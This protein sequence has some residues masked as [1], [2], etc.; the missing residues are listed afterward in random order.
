MNRE[1][2]PEYIFNFFPLLHKKL[3]RSRPTTVVTRQQM[4]LMH[5]I[6][7]RPDKPM[8]YYGEKMLISKPNLSK[9]VNDLIEE[10]YLTRKRDENDRRVVTIHLTDE[11]HSLVE[12][13]FKDMGNQI[14][15]SVKVLTDE[16]VNELV[17]SFDTIQR[18]FEKLETKN[19][20]FNK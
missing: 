15:E 11:G 4:D 20:D 9:L 8:S 12:A 10:G 1:K 2:L 19:E 13:F 17:K 6:K 16:E 5:K 14:I 3:L 18:L 7:F